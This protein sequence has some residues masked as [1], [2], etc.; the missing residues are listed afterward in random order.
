M[1]P[2]TTFL[3]LVFVVVVTGIKQGYE[4]YLRHKSD[5]QVNLQEFEVVRNGKLQVYF[6][7]FLFLHYLCILFFSLA[8]GFF[9]NYQNIKSKD[10]HVGDIVRVEDDESFPCDLILISS[11]NSEG[12]C[13]I[14]TANLDGETNYK[15]RFCFLRLESFHRFKLDYLF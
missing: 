6:Y 13:Y 5:R 3:P 2:I 1:S 12:K 11:S 9:F 7:F 15:V 14:T 10:I 4:D 8:I